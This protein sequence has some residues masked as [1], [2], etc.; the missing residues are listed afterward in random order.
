M[1][2]LELRIQQCMLADQGRFKRR[3]RRLEKRR[4]G[5]NGA[6]AG[7]ARL[8]EEIESSEQ[9]LRRR[10]QSLPTP[11][12]PA[13]LPIHDKVE[14][15]AR[16]IE[17]HPAVIVC[18]E[19]GSGKTTQLA[20]IC[21][22]IGR[23]VA[24]LIGHTQPRRVAARSTAARIAA[25][26][27]SQ[28]GESVGYKLR[29][30]QRVGEN[31]CLKVL[32]DGMLLAEI[33]SDRDLRNYDTIIIDEAHERSL[34]IDFLLGYL[35]RLLERR[36][37]LK[38]IISSAT[39]DTER[40][41]EFFA[42]APIVEVSGRGFP[43]ALRYQPL[44]DGEDGEPDLHGSI[45]ATAGALL[46]EGPGDM[47]V[48]LPG[49]RDIRDAAQRLRRRFGEQCDVLPVF[50]RLPLS[51]QQ[52]LFEAH[53]KRRIVL[54][55]NVAETS[56]T[57][58]DVRFVIDSGLARISRYG[59][60]GSV[61][62]LPI[63]PISRASA[64]QRAGR[65]GRTA[66]GICVRL[67]SEEDYLARA[68]FTEPEIR[69]TNLAA[70]LLDMRALGIHDLD[71]FPFLDTPDRRRVNDGYRLLRELGAIDGEDRLTELGRR[72]ARFPLDPH[73]GRMILAAE[74]LDCLSQVLVVASALSVPDA[75]ERPPE[76]Q[77]AAV[78]AHQ[79]YQ[80]ERSDFM[81]LLKLWEFVHEQTRG[82][83]GNRLKSFCRKHFLS[84]PRLREWQ[85]VHRQ[86][87]EIVREMGLRPRRHEAS[88]SRIHRALLTGLL[89][90]IG[91]RNA[92]RCYTGLHGTMFHISAQSCQSN[93]R[94]RWVV[95][96][97]LVETSR[98]LAHQVA[99]IR[100]EWIERAGGDLLRRTY[101]DAHWDA[102]VGEVMVYEQTSLHGLTVTPRRR[103]R[104]APVSRE[105]AHAIF[106]QSAVMDRTLAS[107]AEFLKKNAAVVDGLRRYE[108]KLRR[109]DVLVAD[110]DVY[111][112]YMSLI[113]EKVCDS[114]S[115]E[116]WRRRAE[117]E[118]PERL[119]MK[120]ESLQRCSLPDG[121]QRDFPDEV[122]FE[123]QSMALVYRFEPGRA[124]D[125]V[126][127]EVP[128]A[129]L[130]RVKAEPFEWLVPGLLAEKVLAMLKL[131][132]KSSRRELLPLADC[133]REFLAEG[134]RESGT[135]AN[136]L[137]AFVRS[138]R[139]VDVPAGV[140]HW[141]QLETRLAPH[142]LM[143]FRV[144]DEGGVCL[145]EGRDILRLQARL[146]ESAGRPA[147][148]QA[149]TGYSR[150]GLR[151][152]VVGTL[153]EVVEEQIDGRLVRGYPALSDQGQSVTLGLFPS[154]ESAA[155]SHGDGVHRLF[156]I[157]AAREIRKIVR[158]LPHLETMELVHAMLPAAP[159]YV[160]VPEPAIGSL[161]R[162]IVARAVGRA[163]P[164]AGQIR[165]E[166]QFRQAASE[167]GARL[168]GVAEAL[169][170]LVRDIL[171]SQ[172]SLAAQCRAQESEVP[173]SS[174][175]DIEEHLANLTFRG[176]VLVT[177]DEVLESYP[178]YLSA[179]RIRLDKL[180]RGGAGDSRKL[181]S[182]APLWDRFMSR[183]ADHA[184]RGRHDPE[185]VRYRWM[186][187]EFRISI[188]AQELG[189][190]IRVSPERLDS[191]W[192][193]VSL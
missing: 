127:L 129:L 41:S 108:H 54:A 107:S 163:M 149:S 101:F 75:R 16:A 83:K 10:R 153:P 146:A 135:L 24:G 85:E 29:F 119:L 130:P 32:T 36:L 51:Q 181:A 81:G 92:E 131:L 69:R 192:R 26:L 27:G 110:D 79:R 103:V 193:K 66:P 164:D 118:H 67:Y 47:L 100:P 18:G 144:I 37:D 72:L 180:R 33:Q 48:F 120:A 122:L 53:I 80:D 49:E 95:A 189:T 115:F 50:A 167:A 138:H 109:P 125:G 60:R 112:F 142:L 116:A 31:C 137:R 40:F 8:S 96:A 2:S 19:T 186:L 172:R 141:Q 190:A 165:D 183:A 98:L 11:T 143:N 99:R 62:R 88:Y 154:A 175:A 64:D 188:F 68:E 25:E 174:Y 161:V 176:F 102:R 147:T 56:I 187:E 4:R 46:E 70:V 86:L 134:A 145:N 94:A 9:R 13:E 133:A 71:A 166:A 157:G 58:P 77:A 12:F 139:G 140:W 158:D 35:K 184:M 162:S 73:I 59:R 114:K 82:L 34:N 21:M 87:R 113:P 23:G 91:M 5:G 170:E 105:D 168:R 45:V 30:D 182:V 17:A 20:K 177:P 160:H 89:R 171:E 104:L 191:Q 15:I 76:A 44:L 90:N 6:N 22:Q 121:A 7:F 155:E 148:P 106:I 14:D 136:A 63:E 55:T 57:V 173:A 169:G 74:E 78:L 1:A 132:P 151:D 150:D 159:G 123:Q 52:R 3:L 61:Q 28:L 38:L 126:T 179:L 65:C 42:G 128:L 178:R 152:W 97:E 124:D 84:L 43:V 39:I 156:S 111:A 185:L 117:R 93:R